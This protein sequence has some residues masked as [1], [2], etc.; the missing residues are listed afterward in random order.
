MKLTEADIKSIAQSGEGYNAEFKINIP[1]KAKELAGEICAFANA[2]GGTILF[3]VDDDN[4]IKG[5][6]IN[7]SDKD[8][9][10]ISSVL[11]IQKGTI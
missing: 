7:L 10:F 8:K 5:I 2:A 1:S 3:G 4:C 9:K 11:N 6:E